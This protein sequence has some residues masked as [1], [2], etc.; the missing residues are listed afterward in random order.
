MIIIIKIIIIVIPE[1][2]G[3]IC[4]LASWIEV[5]CIVC[6][7]GA[8]SLV[9]ETGVAARF[10]YILKHHHHQLCFHHHP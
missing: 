4:K 3:I 2:V 10:S 6:I 9:G 5:A 7:L 8:A 1:K